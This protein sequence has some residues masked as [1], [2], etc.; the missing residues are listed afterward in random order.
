MPDYFD[1]DD[2]EIDRMLRRR[3]ASRNRRGRG[4]GNEEAIQGIKNGLKSGVFLALFGII[5]ML[6]Y[7]SFYRVDASAEGVVLR[8]GEKVRTVSPGLQMKMP[9]P[10]ESVYTVPVMKIQSLEFGFQTVSADRKTVYAPRSEELDAVADMLTGDLNLAHVEWIVQ[11]Q[12][13]DSSKSLFNVGGD[14]GGYYMQRLTKSGI[15]PAIPDTIR[16]VSETV[17]RKLVGDRSVD[18]ALTMG[19]EEIANEA[20]LSIQSMLD[21]Y[22]IGVQI[23]TVKLQTTSPPNSV[24]DAFQ[25]VN[26]ARQNKERVVNEAEG[27]RNRQIPAARG[28]RDQMISEA[29]GYRELNVLETQGLISAFNAKLAEYEKAPE[30]TKQRLYLEAME[31]V[32]SSV[33][34]KTI[35][36]DSVNQMLPILNIGDATPGNP[37]RGNSK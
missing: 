12:I 24:K 35:I 10:I 33:G 19:R 11:Y 36:D 32:L 34:N 21:E 14:A 6:L 23:V 16:D 3:D 8:F 22:D 29:E 1:D 5:A 28:R 18:S 7:T 30:I 4:N 27:E 26:R 17:M 31:E 15:N 9:W 13:S 20:K 25:E 37:L 2:N